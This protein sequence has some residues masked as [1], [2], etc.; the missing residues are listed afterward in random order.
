MKPKK[1]SFQLG[2]K[3]SPPL[4][5]RLAQ[6]SKVDPNNKKLQAIQYTPT[7]NY[8]PNKRTKSR[9][10]NVA[11]RR[12]SSNSRN[13]LGNKL[14]K[15]NQQP[16]R[17][18]VQVDGN[19][20]NPRNDFFSIRSKSW[21]QQAIQN[22]LRSLKKTKPP[23]FVVPDKDEQAKKRKHYLT[24]TKLAAD[25]PKYRRSH[26]KAKN[27]QSFRSS[28]NSKLG[29]NQSFNSSIRKL[30]QRVQNIHD[31]RRGLQD[32]SIVNKHRI[33]A[34]KI[35]KK[36]LKGSGLKQSLSTIKQ[37]SDIKERSSG[38]KYSKHGESSR[39]DPQHFPPSR[40]PKQVTIEVGIPKAN[41]LNL[42][43]RLKSG[44]GRVIQGG[45][46]PQPTEPNS[47][48][49][50]LN[51]SKKSVVNLFESMTPLNNN[52]PRG[53]LKHEIKKDFTK[54]LANQL[55]NQ[56]SHESNLTSR[57]H[58]KG[59]RT[60]LIKVT[61]PQESSSQKPM[62]K[63][64]TEN[65]T[66]PSLPSAQNPHLNLE[67]SRRSANQQTLRKITI[68]GDISP[69]SL[70]KA[71]M[72]IDPDHEAF[73]RLYAQK[74]INQLR[75]DSPELKVYQKILEK[76]LKRN[77]ITTEFSP[78]DSREL[79][80]QTIEKPGTYSARPNI[81]MTSPQKMNLASANLTAI[82]GIS[83]TGRSETGSVPSVRKMRGNRLSRNRFSETNQKKNFIQT[84]GT[85]TNPSSSCEFHVNK[86]KDAKILI[87]DE[88]RVPGQPHPFRLE[89]P[90]APIRQDDQATA[91]GG[92]TPP[93]RKLPKRRT[94]QPGRTPPPELL[95]PITIESKKSQILLQ[96][97]KE[98]HKSN[99]FLN[100]KLETEKLNNF[101]LQDNMKQMQKIIENVK[102]E[103]EDLQAAHNQVLME[104]DFLKDRVQKQNAEIGHLFEQIN[105]Q[106]QIIRA[107]QQQ[108]PPQ[109]QQPARVSIDHL[110]AQ[111]DA[112]AV[113]NAQL[114][115]VIDSL[116]NQIMERNQQDAQI[117]NSLQY[118]L[119]FD[120]K[121]PSNSGGKIGGSTQQSTE[122]MRNI[123]SYYNDALQIIEDM[124]DSTSLTSPKRVRFTEDPENNPIYQNPV[125]VKLRTLLTEYRNLKKPP[126]KTSVVIGDQNTSTIL[127]NSPLRGLKGQTSG[128]VT[129]TKLQNQRTS[130]KESQAGLRV[131]KLEEQN[132]RLREQL[133]TAIR[134][135]EASEIQNKVYMTNLQWY[136]E[137]LGVIENKTMKLV[138][139][140]DENET[141]KTDRSS[142]TF[143]GGV[144]AI[145]N[146]LKE[147][148]T[149]LIRRIEELEQQSVHFKDQVN[150]IGK[151]FK[152]IKGD[153][154]NRLKVDKNSEEVV[155]SRMKELQNLVEDL[156]EEK[157]SMNKLNQKQVDYIDQ[158]EQQMALCAKL[159][160]KL[161]TRARRA[162]L[163]LSSESPE[164]SK[165]SDQIEESE[166][167]DSK[168]TGE[169]MELENVIKINEKALKR[170]RD[171]IM[172]EMPLKEPN[173]SLAAKDQR[174][175]ANQNLLGKKTDN[176]I[177]GEIQEENSS[178]VSKVYR[179]NII[180]VDE[181]NM[182]Q[183]R[184]METTIKDLSMKIQKMADKESQAVQTSQLMARHL[185]GELNKT[186]ID[187]DFYM[188][189]VEQL[190]VELQIHRSNAKV[191]EADIEG[192]DVALA[193]LN[194]TLLEKNT[195][196]NAIQN[197]I[198]DI[199][200]KLKSR[201][202]KSAETDKLK[203]PPDEE[204]SEH[205]EGEEEKAMEVLEAHKSDDK[206]ML[207]RIEEMLG[208]IN[209]NNNL[210]S[211]NLMPDASNMMNSIQFMKV[212]ET[213][214]IGGARALA[215]IL[216]RVKAANANQEDQ[217]EDEESRFL[218]N[219]PPP[220]KIS[221]SNREGSDN[222]D[223]SFGHESDLIIPAKIKVQ[224]TSESA[225]DYK[226]ESITEGLMETNNYKVLEKSSSYDNLKRFNT[227]HDIKNPEDLGVVEKKRFSTV[228]PQ[229]VDTETNTK[230]GTNSGIANIFGGNN[231]IKQRIESN[232]QIQSMFNDLEK[233]KREN[234]SLRRL[235][236]YQQG[237]IDN[238]MSRGAPGQLGDQSLGGYTQPSF[239]KEASALWGQLD[240]GRDSI[241]YEKIE[242]E[243]NS[244]S[245]RSGP[246][247]PSGPTSRKT[248]E[249]KEHSNLLSWKKGKD[250]TSAR[251]L[252]GIQPIR[253]EEPVIV[254]QGSTKSVLLHGEPGKRYSIT[255][256]GNTDHS[257][258]YTRARE[259]NSLT[260]GG[261]R[262]PSPA[263]LDSQPGFLQTK[264]DEESSQEYTMGV[265]QSISASDQQKLRIQKYQNDSQLQK[266]SE[267][268]SAITDDSKIEFLSS[269]ANL[270]SKISEKIPR[271]FSD[272]RTERYAE[273]NAP[274]NRRS[275]L[276][277]NNPLKT[278]I[279]PDNTLDSKKNSDVAL[280]YSDETEKPQDSS[281]V[282]D[283][284][285]QE[286][287]PL[288][289]RLRVMNQSANPEAPKNTRR[290]PNPLSPESGERMFTPAQASAV[291]TQDNQMRINISI[292][293]QTGGQA[294]SHHNPNSASRDAQSG[295]SSGLA[296][297]ATFGIRENT[298]NQTG[299]SYLDIDL[300]G[301]VNNLEEIRFSVNQLRVTSPNKGGGEE[302]NTLDVKT[303]L[304][305]EIDKEIQ[306][307]DLMI[308][309][310]DSNR[311]EIKSRILNL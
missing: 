148:V 111:L 245:K 115:S 276:A 215:G 259:R 110:Q 180:S 220:V 199:F 124:I 44:G 132:A 102:S 172:A 164:E 55:Q 210:N 296:S 246:K 157:N 208:S 9:T 25:H 175:Y 125:I 22:N 80:Q 121:F 152:I 56:R 72:K 29:Q 170:S 156:Q 120:S 288:T 42:R 113:E 255:L 37:L 250:S 91:N 217:G 307:I 65:P 58:N 10:K 61:K 62:L 131:Q 139:M 158:M 18:T 41:K 130:P 70:S 39:L 94:T 63:L 2:R 1:L 81:P 19:L 177:P 204:E 69:D 4:N 194:N 271:K 244:S 205:I 214:K 54:Y 257:N 45:L 100:D 90:A 109:D 129:P 200:G 247:I 64:K 181:I 169:L 260:G 67:K 20:L 167:K 238:I 254:P 144:G 249:S 92:V 68:E 166:V 23:S 93:L 178:E 265:S 51:F 241:N 239:N 284:K 267:Q 60:P 73:K 74:R 222:N 211:R 38:S 252:G 306:G 188:K 40:D 15:N 251:G 231:Y 87:K 133:K 82:C 311:S 50:F 206:Q 35:A 11:V 212:Q 197:G 266:I 286:K 277:Q 270:Q 299:S 264:I 297:I 281:G 36:R 226:L 138:E 308:K 32:P 185:E 233:L 253:V 30:Q 135:K 228:V 191:A 202:E 269:V 34:N 309:Q 229:Q 28:S 105:Q 243:K 261:R 183:M 31:S 134:D 78:M 304:F 190:K 137:K 143:S 17:A 145:D 184:A 52:T 242:S 79:S 176:L 21:T 298:Q 235:Q 282:T 240:Q 213:P 84:R 75:K 179:S 95:Q 140:Q 122:E 227:N 273:L 76:I 237:L 278:F 159:I 173:N 146:A 294:S 263:L 118:S 97:L 234:E 203:T 248:Q 207:E 141:V 162:G 43:L 258:D 49:K 186:K 285:S 287:K 142:T 290:T 8:S 98:A 5:K 201:I 279:V 174:I 12:I 24:S 101:K 310:K 33:I 128:D 119:G 198:A 291:N 66:M 209:H 280:N 223:G 126:L 127:V 27:T 147:E 117:Q 292:N 48:S 16:K 155:K 46:Q 221:S 168:E 301:L 236:L 187:R 47:A 26:Y 283:P 182:S 171:D 289:P 232:S 216:E 116:N 13:A 189:Q 154:M 225:I 153:N 107:N 165:E 96:K 77:N 83:A 163:N 3:Q 103:S 272:E 99:Q 224:A 161:K 123:I 136:R 274:E 7:A 300:K 295:Y 275:S 14:A 106:N 256:Q 108:Q 302:G 196:L 218:A 268:P 193:R 88:G 59:D 86:N 150:N 160:A 112:F 149:F 53:E 71:S 192:K 114:K 305:D 303:T 89:M 57:T 293:S 262:Q 85:L 6:K 151:E 195:I 219:V 104:N 230:F